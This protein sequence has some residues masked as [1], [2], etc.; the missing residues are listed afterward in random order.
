MKKG[1]EFVWSEECQ[2]AFQ[3]MKNELLFL[4]PPVRIY[5]QLFVRYDKFARG[6]ASFLPDKITYYPKLS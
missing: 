4:S 1:V 6:L 2:K 3:A 5:H